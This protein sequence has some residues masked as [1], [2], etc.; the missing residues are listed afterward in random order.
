MSS[1]SLSTQPR[2]VLYV[3]GSLAVGGA[4]RHVVAV[5]TGLRQ[6][7]WQ[8]GVFAL[9]PQGPL[10]SVL[11]AVGVQVMGPMMPAWLE[12]AL[13][14]RLGSWAR[15]LCA[16]ATLAAVLLRRRGTVVHFFLPAAY[17]L[18]GLAAWLVGAHPRIMS[19]RSLNRYQL[20]HPRYRKV[21][22]FLHP[23]MDVLLG[24]SAA[25]VRELEIE[26][27]G[28]TPVRLIY[29]G[30]EPVA[31]PMGDRVRS[32]HELGL[33]N[34][35][36]VLVVV[37]NLIPYKGHADLLQGLAQV[38]AGLPEGWRLMCVGRDD[39]IQPALQALAADLG[40]G[41]NVLWLGARMDVPACLVAADI[42]VSSSHEEG[43][44]NAVLEAMLAGLPMVVTDV[45]GN[46]D[47]VVDGVTG[48]VVPAHS[49]EALGQAILR[50]ARDPQRGAM[51]ARGRARVIET[52]SMTACLDAYEALY[53]E[54]MSM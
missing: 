54:P 29:N 19:R 21:E 49:P 46:P 10:R 37:A 4:E 42:A 14:R 48:F 3:I 30:I 34:A 22:H 43:F 25:V 8:T 47:A 12:A 32:R 1:T 18:G 13:G 33:D 5:A 26:A 16:V 39:G 51:G 27:A 17:I 36:L 28:Q 20:K 41:A 38:S 45:G 6:R 11:E 23:R 31:M 35:A 9:S 2:R 15:S 44:S 40:I 24:N 52:F 50:L 7:G 53:V